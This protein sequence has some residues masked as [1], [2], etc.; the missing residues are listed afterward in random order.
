MPVVGRWRGWSRGV[1]AA[2]KACA[3][4][5]ASLSCPRHSV[6]FAR[7]SNPVQHIQK[8]RA[9]GLGKRPPAA[10]PE[11][12]GAAQ[13][14]IRSRVASTLPMLA[15]VSSSPLCFTTRA[16]AAT[17]FA[18]SGISPVTTTSPGPQRVGDP[19]VGLVR[20]AADKDA[21]HQRIGR[22]AGCRRSTP[23]PCACHGG[24]PPARPRPSPGRHRRR[25]RSRPISHAAPSRERRYVPP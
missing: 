13:I 18:A 25:C 3:A 1:H 24:W 9:V 10:L 11:R 23:A 6:G 2:M 15:A 17:H 22:W 12:I 19:F 8:P 16:P 21:F 4:R 7:R 5:M 20:A 14:G